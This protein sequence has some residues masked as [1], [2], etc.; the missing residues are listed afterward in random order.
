MC[1]LLVGLEN[2]FI[3]VFM[4]LVFLDV[5]SFFNNELSV[6]EIFGLIDVSVFVW[7][8]VL[9]FCLMSFG[10]LGW[11]NC[12]Y[13]NIMKFFIDGFSF[14]LFL[15]VWLWWVILIFLCNRLFLIKVVKCWKRFLGCLFG[16]YCME[17]KLMKWVLVVWKL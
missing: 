16:L 12:N 15:G 11:S 10:S 9:Y 5:L 8:F 17:L 3:V 6:C 14:L 1:C 7:S 4:V 2:L 13:V